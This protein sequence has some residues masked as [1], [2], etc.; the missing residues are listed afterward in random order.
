M[1]SD[2]HL[3]QGAA[4]SHYF[5]PGTWGGVGSVVFWFPHGFVL[6]RRGFRWFQIGGRPF[7]RWRPSRS[8]RWRI[9]SASSRK[10][11]LP[12]TWTGGG[13]GWKVEHFMKNPIGVSLIRGFCRSHFWDVLKKKRT[14]KQHGD[15]TS[16]IGFH[17]FI[18]PLDRHESWFQQLY[19]VGL[20]LRCRGHHE[21]DGPPK[22]HQAL[23]VFR[24]PQ[25][26]LKCSP[27]THFQ[28]KLSWFF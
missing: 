13:V 9:W 22:H 19:F 12:Q 21:D 1:Q 8:L 3:H 5:S 16:V 10:L 11:C 25:E 20:K 4:A 2:Q 23:W 27:K 6:G 18:G 17:R 24:R 28:N 15:V 14:S 7:G 26:C